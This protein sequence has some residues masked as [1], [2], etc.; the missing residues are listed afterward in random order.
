[1]IG[2]KGEQANYIIPLDRAFLFPPKKRIRKALNEIKRFV[3]KHTRAKE[4]L[5]STEINEFIHK[6]SKNI[7]RKISA[8]LLKE[9]E[10]VSVYLETGKQLKEYLSKKDALKKQKEKK[11]KEKSDKKKEDQPTKGAPEGKAEEDEKKLEEKKAKEAAIKSADMKRK[12][13]K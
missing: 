13:G 2:M 5:V 7:P 3:K 6:N 11:S 12:T 8:T 4:I 1:M 9:N 10:K